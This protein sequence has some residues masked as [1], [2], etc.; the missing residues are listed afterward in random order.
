MG[1]QRGKGY[2]ADPSHVVA[3][4]DL[5]VVHRFLAP[6]LVG[7]GTSGGF[8]TSTSNRQFLVPSRGG[9]GILNQ[10]S[11]SC[12]T[13]FASGGGATASFAARGI[14]VPLLSPIQPYDVGRA[15][16]NPPVDG[17]YAPLVDQ[18]AMPNQVVRG[19]MTFGM[20]SA[21]AWGCYPP[22]SATI[23]LPPTPAELEEAGEF[24][25]TGAYFLD[26]GDPAARILGFIK[27]CAA[28]YTVTTSVQA[29]GD[30][31]ENYTSGVLTATQLTGDLDH[32]TYGID[33]A[34]TGSAA[35]WLTFLSALSGGS[36]SVWQS[37]QAQ[38]TG[39]FVNSWDVTWGWS[40]VPGIS[41]GLYQADASAIANFSDMAVWDV[42][43]QSE[44]AA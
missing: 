22:T 2:I 37:L 3:A 16:D 13:G 19:C 38:L 30:A 5:D 8:P 18:G 24:L 11:Y 41:G 44:G 9:P 40:D 21:S 33:Y 20:A 1:A 10:F 6:K 28:K 43:Q 17:V 32:Y 27:A 14:S 29:S 4:R 7:A 26:D 42:T 25:L 31:F 12:C 39:Y 35:N 23:N 15:I 36:T 34:W